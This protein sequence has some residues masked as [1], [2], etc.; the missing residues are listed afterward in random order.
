MD[1]KNIVNF[2]TMFAIIILWI[3]FILEVRQLNRLD[4]GDILGLSVIVGLIHL[5]PLMV[6]TYFI[7]LKLGG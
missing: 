7:L 3:R 4:H 5:L 1:S 6:V 2:T